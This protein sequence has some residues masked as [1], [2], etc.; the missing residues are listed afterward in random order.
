[1]SNPVLQFT[2]HYR[3]WC[4]HLY[5]CVCVLWLPDY[6]SRVFAKKEYRPKEVYLKRKPEIA[7]KRQ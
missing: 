7:D 2:I 5:V 6:N 3:L 1:M 4:V